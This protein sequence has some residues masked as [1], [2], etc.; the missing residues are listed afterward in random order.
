MRTSLAVCSQ[1]ATPHSRRLWITMPPSASRTGN[2]TAS[3]RE[4][5]AR[6]GGM[7]DAARSEL[8]ELGGR[9]CGS[10]R[11]GLAGI[12]RVTRAAAERLVER[13]SVLMAA[14]CRYLF[15]KT[16]QEEA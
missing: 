9:A 12:S 16:A 5:A 4:E 13:T 11:G 8:G 14:D 10:S 2:S 6:M 15:G 1:T 3:V 7:S